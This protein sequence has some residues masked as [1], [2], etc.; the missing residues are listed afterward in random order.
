VASWTD[1][2][3]IDS[4]DPPDPYGLSAADFRAGYSRI[5]AY[6]CY[7]G[8]DRHTAEE[9]ATEAISEAWESGRRLKADAG[10][11]RTAAKHH[12]VRKARDARWS[13]LVR[14]QAKGYQP[15]NADKDGTETYR[16]LEQH[17]EL[18]RAMQ[19]LSKAQREAMALYLDGYTPAEIADELRM[20]ERTVYQRLKKA[21]EHL[22]TLI[23]TDAREETR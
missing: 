9:A 11:V 8:F 21:R 16:A 14:L 15:P 2:V 13:P 22:R 18:V 1:F 3:P 5:V 6:L 23:E 20:A 19:K 10:W 7:Q 17:D 4:D 12:A